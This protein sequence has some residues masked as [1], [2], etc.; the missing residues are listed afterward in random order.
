MIFWVQ[1]LKVLIHIFKMEITFSNT[2]KKFIVKEMSFREKKLYSHFFSLDKKIGKL[3]SKT[4][5]RILEFYDFFDKVALSECIR[6]MTAFNDSSKTESDFCPPS[7]LN[8]HYLPYQ[9]AGVEF[10]CQ[11]NN[12][13]L[14]DEMGLGKTIQII[15]TINFLN[16]FQLQK[17]IL[18]ICPASLKYNWKNELEKWLTN[19]Y[20]IHLIQGTKGIT[21]DRTKQNIYIINF[22]I[23]SKNSKLIHENEFDLLVVDEA[24]FLKN[25]KTQRS[26]AVFGT[27][28]SKKQSNKI[29]AT[30]KIFSTGTPIL[31]KPKDL[32]PM[33]NYLFPSVFWNEYSFE[34][35]YCDAKMTTFGRDVS[36]ASNL[37]ELNY[38]LRISGMVR[39][40][41]A[42]VLKDLPDKTR[43]LIEVDIKTKAKITTLKWARAIKTMDLSSFPLEEIAS[44]RKQVGIAK[45]E[46]IVEYVTQLLENSNKKIILFAH[47]VEVINSYYNLLIQFNPVKITGETSIELRNENVDK[48]QTDDKCRLFIG[49]LQAAGVGLTLTASDYVIMAELDWNPSTMEQAEDRAHRITQKNNVMIDYFVVND[50]IESNI[51]RTMLSKMKIQHKILN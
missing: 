11:R 45:I 27:I 12:I 16:T 7:R 30:R 18:I 8:L 48:F 15:G 1:T 35:R 5:F 46:T 23:L 38:L 19:E 26:K 44:Y 24:H 4:V 21:R 39:R 51:A 43:R 33:L 6:Q 13:L 14:A 10:C 29:K 49:N 37:E 50:S 47:H 36:G 25:K 2:L 42:E 41:K 40:L 22:D 20:G 9:K 28:G 31:S 34:E 17:E 3:T 32:F